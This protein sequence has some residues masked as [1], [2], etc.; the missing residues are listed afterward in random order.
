MDDSPSS[1]GK[2]IRQNAAHIEKQM[3]R[4]KWLARQPVKLGRTQLRG[5]D[6]HA[7]NFS[8]AGITL[9]VLPNEIKLRILAFAMK[10]GSVGLLPSS[11]YFRLTTYPANHRPLL[12]VY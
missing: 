3:K 5:T 9:P 6:G 12:R 10:M 2:K 4:M 1:W 7:E 8:S 11:K